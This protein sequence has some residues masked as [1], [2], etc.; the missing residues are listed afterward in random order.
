MLALANAII[1]SAIFFIP[2][3]ALEST[4]PKVFTKVFM[5]KAIAGNV[6]AIPNPIPPIIPPINK[7]KPVPIF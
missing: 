6:A 7:P 2:V 4:L 3:V 1:A 5:L